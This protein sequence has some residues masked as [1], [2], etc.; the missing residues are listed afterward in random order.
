MG[1][2]REFFNQHLA[3]RKTHD[4]FPSFR[5]CFFL[6]PRQNRSDMR[7]RLTTLAVFTVLAPIA[8]AG[9][10]GQNLEREAM[11]LKSSGQ[12]REAS[13]R[14][15]GALS[16]LVASAELDRMQ[17]AHAEFLLTLADNLASKI[18]DH[19]GF[20]AYLNSLRERPAVRSKPL[21]LAW[22]D[23]FRAMH[24]LRA[25]DAVAAKAILDQLGYVRT[26]QVLGPLDN[27]RGTGFRRK[28]VL[29]SAQNRPL[30]AQAKTGTSAARLIGRV[31]GKKRDVTYRAVDLS[32][33]PL[34]K[35][36]LGA[37][38]R[39]NKQVLAYALFSVT[40]ESA[41]DACLRLASTG[42]LVVLVNGV[43]VLRRDCQRRPLG[44]D[45]DVCALRLV[46]G[47]NL[48]VVK[49]CTQSGPFAARMRLTE[50]GGNPLPPSVKVSADPL[51]IAEA[52]RTHA[53]AGAK[54]T[55]VSRGGVDWYQRKLKSLAQALPDS[56]SDAA[57]A[58]G[59]DAY[60]YAFLLALRGE[61]DEA[62]RRDRVVAK[63]A[64]ALLP[65]FGPA[66]YLLGFT[67]IR[68]GASAADRDENAR[69]LAYVEA[70]RAWPRSAEAMW[71]L[72]VI[73]REQRGN[74]HKAEAWI[75]KALAVNP[76]YGYAC[77]ENLTLL[78]AREFGVGLR[79]ALAQYLKDP[80]LAARPAILG[81]AIGDFE[82]R[83]EILQMEQ[84]QRRLLAIDYS[85]RTADNLARTLMRLGKTKE[86]LALA[87]KALA[88]AP[89]DRLAHSL[90]AGLHVATGDLA[91]AA[92]VWDRW[93]GVCPEDERAWLAL[94]DL[95]AR[96]GK[97]DKQMTLLRRAL[98]LNPNLKEQRRKLEFLKSD[99]ET[100]YTGYEIDA[101]AILE[102]DPG[103]PKDAI[104]S[105]DAHYYLLRHK[106]VRAYRDGT[107]STYEHFV[108]RVLTEE[109]VNFFDTYS[110]PFHGGDQTA[111][112]LEAKVVKPDGTVSQANLGRAYWV[113]LPPISVGDVVE[114]KS[115]VD[116]RS[117]TFFGDY[118]GL[119]HLFPAN[120]PVPVRRS[121]LDLILDP[122]RHYYY[123]SIGA[124]KP[125]VERLKDGA[126]HRSW[127]MTNLP[128][129]ESELRAPSIRESG[130]L[131]RVSTY[132]DWNAFASWWWNLIRKQTVA[133]P[134][135]KSKVQELVAGA[136]SV[137]DKI[138]R[139]YEFVVT[140]VR[141]KAWEFGVH[142]YKPYSV[143]VIFDRKHGD[144]KDKA[145]L[146]NAMLGEIGVKA[147]PVLIRG[148]SFRERDDLTL[149]LVEH[150]NHC[151]T[152]VPEQK[153]VKAQFLDGTAE[154]HPV[155]TL[156]SM[157]RGAHVLVVQGSTGKV[158]S[159]P[160]TKPMVNRNEEH[161]RVRIEAN[162][163]ANI[164]YVHRPH[165]NFGPPV[166][167]RYG[168]E[169]GKRRERIA[170]RLAK[171]FGKV[172][173]VDMQFS[174]LEKLNVPAE[175]RVRFRVRGFAA[176][177]GESLR[178][179]AAFRQEN[180]S[181][182]TPSR[183]RTLDMLLRT[184]E[185]SDVTIVY[186]APEG[187]EWAQVADPVAYDSDV[188]SFHLTVQKVG[189]TITLHRVR[190]FRAQRI[191]A[192]QYDAFKR[193][194]ETVDG[195]ESKELRLRRKQK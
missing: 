35:L 39:P 80:E 142:G 25:G 27:E 38:F 9:L 167:A 130:P 185:A 85:T 21:L 103:A 75:K 140:E 16:A 131:I 170:D 44:W 11:E 36:D 112:I 59:M 101:K 187:F 28:G 77:A 70:L 81:A 143:G 191:E 32:A 182:L 2:R 120:E 195:A 172:E 46:P 193:L 55:P 76:R 22:V 157:D 92:H 79:L 128:R 124:P 126:E 78:R 122:G 155:D 12:Y 65:D 160:W 26:F 14:A 174:P 83:S 72:G 114:I 54:A 40:T 90:L 156:P 23:H 125:V 147:Y 97:T 132:K 163:D 8:I 164:E 192:A 67:S 139:I 51:A 133:T 117:P 49:L 149:P 150:F 64:A 110:P 17:E 190:E 53:L 145:I 115:R 20:V 121:R 184:P 60:R 183:K 105:K 87:G 3:A 181:Q 169:V 5:R 58:L 180:L 33:V 123:Q 158:R 71:S 154:Y 153:G 47:R 30:E 18:P 57:K 6:T 86:A 108:A 48:V 152:Y 13:E 173:I 1:L 146:I 69:R 186:E 37:R 84:A 91:G 82:R 179:R 63:Q 42:S 74:L 161:Y 141:Y 166:R 188:G 119:V 100:F 98:D 189:G 106:L 136:T 41:R 104:E 178:V 107:T 118:F 138:R 168:N 31:R 15:R 113:D 127:E 144:C 45:Q 56:G 111:R 175:Y 7:Q 66:H 50:L 34:A 68:R 96:E 88:L 93:L 194:T 62:S 159:I 171:R 102:K 134:A 109:G 89:Q 148:E 52:S 10:Q 95:A 151:I 99:G 137:E 165:L 177:A 29:E 129:R 135:I 4:A 162:G 73:E 24:S 176:R 43:E 19:A 61:D 94:A 116:D